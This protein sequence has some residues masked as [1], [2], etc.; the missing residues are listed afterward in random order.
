MAVLDV[1]ENE[2]LMLNAKHTGNYL[3]NEFNKLKYKYNKLGDIRGHG[4]F[5]G[6]E[7]VND[8][9]E[10]EP[11][12]ALASNIVNDLRE[13]A[14]LFSTDGPDEN[15]LK[16]KPPMVLSKTDADFLIQKVDASLAKFH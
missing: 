4:Y 13:N 2:N 14:V 11:A 3:L 12:T 8:G 16:F 5:L 6:L 7:L 9:D 1:I 10:L 15:V